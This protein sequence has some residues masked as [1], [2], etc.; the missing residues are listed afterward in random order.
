MDEN[1]WENW[2]KEGK[3]KWMRMCGRTEKKT[4]EGEKEENMWEK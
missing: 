2:T 3:V 4:E 1:V